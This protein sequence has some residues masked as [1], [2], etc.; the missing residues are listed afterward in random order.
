MKN[1]FIQKFEYRTLS[2]FKFIHTNIFK[3]IFQV[4][5]NDRMHIGQASYWLL[6]QLDNKY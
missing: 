1:V 4:D 6:P 3:A 2:W 5:L